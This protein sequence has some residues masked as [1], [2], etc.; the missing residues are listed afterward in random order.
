MKKLPFTY[1]FLLKTYKKEINDLLDECDWITHIDNITICGTVASIANKKGLKVDEKELRKS[2]EIK[3]KSLKLTTAQ[4]QA[5]YGNWD[6]GVPKIIAM[7]YEILE[8]NHK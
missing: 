6:T 2:Y 7:I 4:W 1:K 8:N 3:V 5:E